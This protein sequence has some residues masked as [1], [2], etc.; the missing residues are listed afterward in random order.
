[1]FAHWT[2]GSW[3]G[4]AQD[5][6]VKIRSCVSKC[7][8]HIKYWVNGN[9]IISSLV[10][11]CSP[12][13][14]PCMDLP[15]C[16]LRWWRYLWT[17]PSEAVQGGGITN[18]SVFSDCTVPPPRC[19]SLFVSTQFCLSVAHRSVCNLWPGCVLCPGYWSCAGLVHSTPGL[20][21]PCWSAVPGFASH[22]RECTSLQPLPFLST[23]ICLQSWPE[24]CLL[25][26]RAT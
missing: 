12:C 13:C 25:S 10:N 2:V 3:K 7:S 8:M 24:L 21:H 5:F 22:S 18:C 9:D 23:G 16:V 19:R 26:L 15:T 20:H 14:G 6:V 1:M 4:L 17:S 11:S